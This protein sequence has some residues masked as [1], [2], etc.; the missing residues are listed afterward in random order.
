MRLRMKSGFTLTIGLSVCLLQTACSLFHEDYADSYRKPPENLH[1]IMAARLTDMSR[2][3]PVTVEQAT[4]RKLEQALATSQPAE[5]LDLSLAD[6]RAAALTN[7]LDLEIE[8]VNPS[9]EQESVN[10]EEAAFEALLFGSVSHGVTDQPS[11]VIDGVASQARSTDYDL[12]VRVPLRTGGTVTVD[13]PY[14]RYDDRT[15]STGGSGN[16]SLVIDPSYDMGLRFS[17]SQPLLRGAGIRANTHAI[18]LAKY[19][20]EVA[21]AR[22]KLAA[23]RILADAD[24]SYWRLYAARRELQVN[25][26]QY[27]L[28]LRQLSDARK[29]VQA[30][31]SPEIEIMRAE[32][33]VAARLEAIIV[34]DT[35]V[36]RLERELK[37][38]MNRTDLPVSSTTTLTP[39]TDPNPLGLQLD[40]EALVD[41]ALVGRMELLEL[42][43]RLA[44]DSSTID[45]ERNKALP[46]IALDYTY[47]ANGVSDDADRVF[48]NALDNDYADQTLALRAEVPLG[49]QAAKARLRRAM[50]ERV[51][52]LATREQ[53][54]QLIA[55][56]V[57]D[58]VDALEQ[59]WQRILAARQEVILSGRT[60]EAEKRQF[61]LGLRTSTDVLEAA[62][63][64]AN[65][66]SREIQALA[67]YEISLIDIAYATGNL[68]GHSSVIWEP[69]KLE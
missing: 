46:W 2:T 52:R 12:G 43:L 13:V 15:V 10:E 53:R 41:N 57:Y 39:T 31:D 8:Y 69:T 18:R 63:R 34:A 48:H 51:Q 20:K 32:S 61:E 67:A 50:L 49:N 24:R 25:Q 55:Q 36:R 22:T 21:D 14:G 47:Q 30:G 5:R 60:Y 38:V 23:I 7:N 66:Q 65:A 17:I 28:A 9:I 62:A 59:D 16:N 6:V 11:R 68:I 44:I 42:E 19:Q 27:D 35:Y 64:L 3:E 29:R 26:E 4:A 56:E 54:R 40:A 1:E 33:G 37:R 58:A 45:F